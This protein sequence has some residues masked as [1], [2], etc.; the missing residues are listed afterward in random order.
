MT[1]ASKDAAAQPARMSWTAGRMQIEIFMVEMLA[2]MKKVAPLACTASTMGFQASI[3]SR[4]WIPG[5]A[6][7]L[8]W[9]QR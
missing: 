4:L 6:G 2:C 7:Y 1:C 5:I 8:H 3:C 9:G